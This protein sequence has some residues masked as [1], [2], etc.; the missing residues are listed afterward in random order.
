MKRYLY[1]T[2]LLLL[3]VVAEVDAQSMVI[4]GGNDHGIALCSKGQI[5]AWGYNANG[6]LLFND[7]AVASQEIV[8]EPRLVNTGTLTFRQ[9]SA[10]SGSHNVALSCYNVV[11]CWGSNENM[12]CGRPKSKVIT[13]ADNNGMPVPVYHGEAPGYTEDGQPGGDYLGNVKY[14]TGTSAASLAILDDGTGRV[15]IWGGN[16]EPSAGVLKT[17]TYQPVF[18]RDENGDPIENV[19]HIAGGDDNVMLIVGSSPDAKVGTVYSIGNWNGRGG[20]GSAT[21][22]IAAPVEIGDGTGKASSNKHINNARVSGIS[23]VGGFVVD[24]VTGYLYGWGNGDW[25]CMNGLPN[26]AKTKYAEKV[27]S[28]EYEEISGETYLTNVKQVIGGNGSGTAVTEEGYVLY[29]GNNTPSQPMGGVAPTSSLTGENT[30]KTGPVFGNYCKGEH[31]YTKETRVDDAVAIS[32]GDMFGFMVNK[33]GDYYSWGSTKSPATKTDVGTLGTG[34]ESDIQTCFKQI[35]INCDEQDMCPE[36]FMV[37]TRK[38]CPGEEIELYCGFEPF[39]KVDPNDPTKEICRD[40]V[41]FF[42]WFKDGVRLNLSKPTDA[43][44]VRKSDPYNKPRI[45]ITDPGVYKVIVT[46]IGNNVPCDNCPDAE[47]EIEIIDMEMPIDTFIP[48]MQCVTSPLR[49]IAADVICFKAEVNDKFYKANQT[50]SFA[51]YKDET[52]PDADSLDLVGLD[53]KT[54]TAQGSGGLLEFCVSGDNVEVHDNKALPSKDTTYTIWVQDVT[55]FETF[56]QKGISTAKMLPS[57]FQS[58]AMLLD[59]YATSDLLSVDVYGK[60]YSGPA[61]VTIT[62]VVFKATLNDQGGYVIGSQFWKGKAQTFQIDD[63]GPNKMTVKYGVNLPG[64]IDRGARYF[65]AMQ[66]T[67]NFNLYK[68]KLPAHGSNV[69]TFVT[70]VID[71]EGFGIYAYGAS[72]NGLGVGDGNPTDDS[73]YSNIRFGKLTDYNCGRIQLT[74]RYG[75]PPCKMPDGN[76]VDIEELNGAIKLNAKKQKFVELCKESD[77]IQLLVKDVQKVA[78]PL[79]FFD[80]L[81]YKDDVKSTELQ[82]D[83]KKTQSTLPAISW[84]EAKAGTTEIYIVKVRDNEKPTSATCYVFDSVR[85]VYNEQP[86]APVIGP[87]AFCENATDREKAGLSNDLKGADFLLY[88][89]KWYTDDTKTTPAQEP[90]L[91]TLTNAASPYSF[92][93]TVTDQKTGCE[94]EPQLVA[95]TVYAIPDEVLP[96][97]NPFCVNDP[98]VTLPESSVTPANTIT[99]YSDLTGTTKVEPDLQTMEAGVYTYSYTLT[100]PAPEACVSAPVPYTITINDYVNLTLD[101]VQTCGKTVV[102]ETGLT[103]PTASLTW[104]LAGSAVL[105]AEF[106]ETSFGSGTIGD[107]EVIGTATGYCDKTFTM[108]DVYVMATASD[109]TGEMSVQYFKTDAVNGVFKDL[110]TQKPAVVTEEAGYTLK[111]YNEAKSPLASC[112]VPDYPAE[113]ETEDKTYTYYVSRVNADGCESQLVEVTVTVYLTPTPIVTPVY[114]C[115]NSTLVQPLTAEINDPNGV[116]GFT[117]KWYDSSKQALADAPVPSVSDA[118]KTTYYVS[119]VS[120]DGAESSLVPLDVTVYGVKEPVLDPTNVLEYCAGIGTGAKLKADI[121]KDPANYYEAAAIVWEMKN[122]A[123]NYVATTP[124]P[125]K[126]VSVTTLYEYQA[127]QTYTIAGS[128]EECK[129]EPVQTSVNV[130]FV[131]DILTQDVLYLKS[132]ADKTTGTFADNVLMQNPN[133]VKDILPDAVLQWYEADCQTPITGTPTPTLD[134]TIPAG[135][136]QNLTYCVSQTLMLPGGS[137]VC[138]SAAKTVNVK[139]SDALPPTVYTYYYCEGQK[140]GDLIAEIN[141]QPGKTDADYEVYWYGQTK[142]ASTTETPETTG[143][144]YAMNN[145]IA[146]VGADGKEKVY[147]Y[148]VAQHDVLTNAVSAA[149]EVK[150]TVKPKPITVVPTVPPSCEEPIDLSTYA[151]VNNVNEPTLTYIFSEDGVSDRNSSIVETTG[152]YFVAAKYDLELTSGY[153]VSGLVCEGEFTP[154]DLTINTLD[155]VSITGPISTCPGTSVELIG[156]AIP[157][158]GTTVSYQWGGDALTEANGATNTDAFKSKNLSMESGKTYSFTLTATAGACQKTSEPHIVTIGMGQVNGSI[159]FNEL[160]NEFMPTSISLPSNSPLEIYSCGGQV[161]ISLDLDGDKDYTWTDKNGTEV[162]KGSSIYETPAYAEWTDETYKVTYTNQCEAT[163]DFT[164]H[165]IPVSSEPVSQ[166]SFEIC[167]DEEFKTE[168]TYNLKPGVTPTIQWYLNGAEISDGFGD[169]KVYFERAKKAKSGQ[170]SYKIQANGCVSGGIANTVKIKPYIVGRRPLDPYVAARRGSITLPVS[171]DYPQTYDVQGID[172][173]EMREGDR[174]E[175]AETVYAGNTYV[176]ENVTSDHQYKVVLSDPEFCN[177]TLDYTLY[178]DAELQLIAKL[179]DTI[180][181]G[182]SEMLE[183]DTAGTGTFRMPDGSPLLEVQQ[184]DPKT[185]SVKSMKDKLSKRDGKLYLPVTIENDRDY[186][187]NFSYMG[188]AGMQVKDTTIKVVVIPAISMTLPQIPVVCEG[189]ETTL[190]VTDVQPMR[191]TVSWTDDPTIV[192]GN[193]METVRVKPTFTTSASH[194]SRYTYSVVAYNSICDRS[195]TYNVYVDVDEPLKGTIEGVTEICQGKTTILNASSY[196]AATYKW[197]PDTTGLMVSASTEVKPNVTTEYRVDMTRGLCSATDK[198]T[199]IVNSNPVIASIDSVALRDRQIVLEP[200][201][202]TAPFTYAVDGQPADV[203]DVKTNLTFARHLV[204]VNDSKGCTTSTIFALDPPEIVIP[205]RFSPNAD[206]VNDTWLI[207]SLAEVYPNS[208]VSIYDRYGKLIKQYL[209]AESDGWDGTYQG[210]KLPSTD[211]WYQITIKEIDREYT[212]HF[213]LIRR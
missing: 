186:N 198:I 162:K 199:V 20:D 85:V 91:T 113:S 143:L 168:F 187:I 110:L 8:P 136:D 81:W 116:G 211:Y 127:Y 133:T 24:G 2:L 35:K 178:V 26:N 9:L 119:Q 203:L 125:S 84:E 38:K 89:V 68:Y 60:S 169:N 32:R 134:P 181:L 71:S 167:E 13:T 140:M 138:Y 146:E 3:G 47:A 52:G 201:F 21:S 73:P 189:E 83:L 4:T 17:P 145:K 159:S 158:A 1:T 109:P 25:G 97:L 164:V 121:E 124:E 70:P 59:V 27:K 44:P 82:E 150:I 64:N 132:Q 28:G 96:L 95:V 22:Y 118:S 197:M 61:S 76:K 10:G 46:Y 63:S 196:D 112:P 141:P 126:S 183:I 185:G 80:I 87:Y 135:E 165:V 204:F 142:P 188:V 177:D 86:L 29:W 98:T 130:V 67:G 7:P 16:V 151:T 131:P 171:F 53:V 128:G 149:Q 207:P 78:D 117:L 14:I 123:G 209:G 129:G 120:S 180:C 144:T 208:V 100:S 62:P 205:N 37:P 154:V 176:V 184:I 75:C 195:K 163:F 50:A 193:T 161:T 6:R 103:P 152:T 90:D 160:G 65:V 74:A 40:A 200:G 172:W 102:H 194:Q 57:S 55:S 33:N 72:A 36:V 39:C 206:G 170:Y 156:S 147:T 139:I 190:T 34:K 5:F 49:P 155:N 30:C 104:T 210:N 94:S 11:Y 12:E 41:Y 79:A 179:K 107:L 69:T 191:T 153:V 88:D 137:A 43:E 122:D 105:T 54:L 166:E 157:D 173:R 48:D 45:N 213:T 66:F 31:G 182:S 42:E 58:E 106:D 114:Y 92:Y 93:F 174:I 111:W 51:V 192:E 202:G 101:S 148:Y 212:G 19:I 23:D 18:I 99:Y 77:P 175:D 56:L 15:V 108:P 115:Q